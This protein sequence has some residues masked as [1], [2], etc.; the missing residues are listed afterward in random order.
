MIDAHNYLQYFRVAESK[1]ELKINQ[2]KNLQD[3]LY[4][5]STPINKEPCSHTRNVTVMA[6][7]TAIIIDMQK[8]IDQQTSAILQRKREAFLLLDQIKPENA[9]LLMERYFNRKTILDISHSIHVTKRQAQRRLNDAIR[10][11]QIVLNDAA[12]TKTPS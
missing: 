10:A 3:R 5:I 1:I 7:T 6:D 4:S 2:I 11:F 12:N 8:E 9:A